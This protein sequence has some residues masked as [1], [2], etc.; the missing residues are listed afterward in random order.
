MKTRM[1]YEK[2]KVRFGGFFVE[3]FLY[4]LRMY[5]TPPLGITTMVINLN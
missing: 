2:G 3:G 1:I 4:V 5:L